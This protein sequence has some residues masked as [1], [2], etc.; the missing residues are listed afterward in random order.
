[1]ILIRWWNFTAFSKTEKTKSKNELPG[2]WSIKK[3]HKCQI[4]VKISCKFVEKTVDDQLDVFKTKRIS[5]SYFVDRL[6]T[7]FQVCFLSLKLSSIQKKKPVKLLFPEKYT[8]H[9]AVEIPNWSPLK[10][11]IVALQIFKFF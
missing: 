11:K 4:I 7:S 5:Y 6:I 3:Y 2:V 1:M 9:S 8:F 10:K